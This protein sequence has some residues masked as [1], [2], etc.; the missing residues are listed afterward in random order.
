MRIYNIFKNVFIISLLFFFVLTSIDASYSDEIVNFTQMGSVQHITGSI[1]QIEPDL[2]KD[3]QIDYKDLYLLASDWD[4]ETDKTL[5]LQMVQDWKKTSYFVPN[6]SQED[7]NIFLQVPPLTAQVGRLYRYI[8]T[9]PSDVKDFE[10][11]LDT[12]P[13]GMV[14]DEELGL[15]WTPTES[16]AGLHDV[17]ITVSFQNESHPLSFQIAVEQELIEQTAEISTQGGMMTSDN[18]ILTVPPNALEENTTFSIGRVIGILD[19]AAKTDVEIVSEMVFVNAVQDTFNQ[20][21]EEFPSD[22][23]LRITIPY[24]QGQITAEEI[25]NGEVSAFL[26]DPDLEMLVLEIATEFDQQAGTATFETTHLSNFFIGKKRDVLSALKIVTETDTDP[27]FTIWHR[28]VPAEQQTA[29]DVYGRSV[30]SG[31]LNAHRL[32]DEMGFR[33]PSRRIDVVV[34]EEGFGD[35]HYS[36]FT[37]TIYLDDDLTDTLILEITA[38]E[39]FHAVQDEYY[40]FTLANLTDVYWWAEASSAWFETNVHEDAIIKYLD[41]EVGYLRQHFGDRKRMHA[42]S[43]GSFVQWA[44]ENFDRQPEEEEFVLE[45]FNQ[46]E[47]LFTSTPFLYLKNRLTLSSTYP[48]FIQDALAEYGVVGG[49]TRRIDGRIDGRVVVRDDNMIKFDVYQTSFQ[50]NQ[51]EGGP[52][53]SVTISPENGVMTAEYD[54]YVLHPPFHARIYEILPRGGERNKVTV[55]YHLPSFNGNVLPIVQPLLLLYDKNENLIADESGPISPNLPFE[56]KNFGEDARDRIGLIRLVDVEVDSLSFEMFRE[57]PGS[58]PPEGKWTIEVRDQPDEIDGISL[59]IP[60]K[61]EEKQEFRVFTPGEFV[62][63]TFITDLSN[64]PEAPQ[65]SIFVIALERITVP[66]FEQTFV[67]I[68]WVASG[69]EPDNNIIT[70]GD[71]TIGVSNTIRDQELPAKPLDSFPA[72][73]VHVNGTTVNDLGEDLYSFFLRGELYVH[74]VDGP[75]TF[76]YDV[77]PQTIIPGQ[78]QFDITLHVNNQSS[79]PFIVNSLE[80]EITPGQTLF[81][82]LRE[83]TDPPLLIVNSQENKSVTLPNLQIQPNSIAKEFLGTTQNARLLIEDNAENLSQIDL[84]QFSHATFWNEVRSEPIPV[85]FQEPEE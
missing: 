46:T 5:L 18:V 62:T 45:T 55:Q 4:N 72:F 3:A 29:I 30:L 63:P 27:R 31:L 12:G 67:T 6:I 1:A 38:H 69:I 2:N 79:L 34:H 47:G 35:G 11:V 24:N 54:D 70:Y 56:I 7:R 68:A 10:L 50:K 84:T 73:L 19:P 20:A 32:A 26:Y 77:S 81:D 58:A 13:N 53:G 25:E 71:S 21:V 82:P 43:M 83:G 66:G 9:L 42:Y 15:M 14:V 41:L 37:G 80:W 51:L 39:Y 40:A 52:S 65:Y 44:S 23:P 64:D 74:Y 85:T 60:P 16:Q 8:P 22:A 76:T 59:E 75:I 48:Q 49:S 28:Q 33:T 36:P 78:T 17:S 61:E 57:A